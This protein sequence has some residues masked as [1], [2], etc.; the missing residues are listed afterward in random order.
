MPRSTEGLAPLRWRGLAQAASPPQPNSVLFV[1]TGNI[2]RSAYAEHALQARLDVVAPGRVETTSVGTWPNQAL[3]VP[4]PLVEI[5]E[6]A[7]TPGLAEH[8]PTAPSAPAIA[9]SDLILTA[10]QEHM[11]TVLAEVPRAISRTF[12]ILEFGTLLRC[13]NERTEGDWFPAGGGIAALASAAARN[14]SLARSLGAPLD[15]ADPFRGPV[16]G[17][18]EMADTLDPILLATADALSRAVGP[19]TPAT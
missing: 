4:E 17:Y 11:R 15:L 1:C 8:R 3:H 5:A 9:R 16:E 6:Q 2:C 19:E 7:G 18:R 13:M 10:T 14:R 12:T